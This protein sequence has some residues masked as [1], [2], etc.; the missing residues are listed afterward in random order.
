MRMLYRQELTPFIEEFAAQHRGVRLGRMF[1]RPAVY[2]GRRLCACLM[3]DG[4]IVRLPDDVA[5]RELRGKAKPFGRRGKAMG[6]WVKYTPGT[7]VAARR[8]TPVLELAARHV[9]RRQAEELTGVKFTS[10]E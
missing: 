2:V 3:D 6:S 5:K 10:A 9:A 1:G 7:A 8:L 4:V